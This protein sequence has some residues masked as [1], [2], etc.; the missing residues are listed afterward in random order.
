METGGAEVAMN[1]VMDDDFDPL[2]PMYVGEAEPDEVADAS[3]GGFADPTNIARVWFTD[4]DL[5]RVR[6]SLAWREKLGQRELD[7]VFGA[8]FALARL[9]LPSPE[10]DEAP[11]EDLS[12]VD[13]SGVAR[14]SGDVFTTFRLAFD[15]FQQ[16]WQEA[17][18]RLA[19]EPPAMP[20]PTVGEVDGVT[21]TLN[22][23]GQP[24]SAQFD[25]EWLE[26]AEG[27]DVADAVLEA[28]AEARAAYRPQ[29][30]RGDE[31]LRLAR[32]HEILMGGLMASLTG[33]EPR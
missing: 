22:E 27:R 10:L 6:V 17:V 24:I 26:D 28:C 20:G 4:G 18:E 21:V 32:E 7:D 14:F 33:K 19:A 13:F 3:Q 1:N 8:A 12:G 23:H 5:T 30:E 29:L 16:R 25:E 31:L 2:A 15:S 9:R 11:R